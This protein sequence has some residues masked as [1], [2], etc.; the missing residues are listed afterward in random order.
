[1]NAGPA[2]PAAM[3]Q[4]QPVSQLIDTAWQ[5]Y[6]NRITTGFSNSVEMPLALAA[7]IGPQ[8]INTIVK[9]YR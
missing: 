9:R 8:G 4:S 3:A 7:S 2:G 5:S 1:M 6:N